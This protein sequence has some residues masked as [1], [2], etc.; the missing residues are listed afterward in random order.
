MYQEQKQKKLQAPRPPARPPYRPQ[1]KPQLKKQPTPA[2][3][4]MASVPTH[5]V[6][7]CRVCRMSED[8]DFGNCEWVIIGRC[9]VNVMNVMHAMNVNTMTTTK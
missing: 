7:F 6:G 3:W 2:P 8:F 4:K 9:N 5:P 1:P